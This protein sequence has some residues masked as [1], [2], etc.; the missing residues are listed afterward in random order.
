[1][2]WCS[3]LP[4]LWFKN[5]FV[6]VESHH[7]YR[8]PD[9]DQQKRHVSAQSWQVWKHG[10][11][12]NS[13]FMAYLLLYNVTVPTGQ[14]PPHQ[15]QHMRT[16]LTQTF[17]VK[18]TKVGG[19]DNIPASSKVKRWPSH[20]CLTLISSWCDLILKTETL[21]LLHS[22]RPSVG[23][24]IGLLVAAAVSET[25]DPCMAVIATLPALKTLALMT[26]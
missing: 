16:G 18:A 20:W 17:N 11:H 9:L 3:A 10:E 8:W 12:G 23:W 2:E 21:I 6:S 5:S 24:P 26:F 15:S 13:F 22:E 1:M 19:E 14:A 25:S 7:F 4:R